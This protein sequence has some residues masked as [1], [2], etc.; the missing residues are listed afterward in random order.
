MLTIQTN[1]NVEA[2]V[3]EAIEKELTETLPA[4]VIPAWNRVAR[5]FWNHTEETSEADIS[6]YRGIL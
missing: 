6:S 4:A 2:T 5:A 3:S 1:S